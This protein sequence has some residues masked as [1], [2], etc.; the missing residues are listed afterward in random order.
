LITQEIQEN[1]LIKVLGKSA[2]SED[3]DTIPHSK[4]TP[5]LEGYFLDENDF[6]F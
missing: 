4:S 5:V 1:E 3:W 6:L 2:L